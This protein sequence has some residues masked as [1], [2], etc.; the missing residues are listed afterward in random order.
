[1][2]E[3]RV[4]R[5]ALPCETCPNAGALGA[6]LAMMDARIESIEEALKGDGDGRKGL[7]EQVE[8][9]VEITKIG[10]STLRVFMWLGAAV[11]AVATGAWQFKQAL[12]G[13]FH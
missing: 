12:Q 13:L 3:L 7:L 10:R 8:T 5:D 6:R 2:S 11:V 4:I 1:V 9:L